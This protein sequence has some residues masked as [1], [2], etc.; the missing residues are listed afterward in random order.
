MSRDDQMLSCSAGR[1]TCTQRTL[2]T[3]RTQ[4]REMLLEQDFSLF[5]HCFGETAGESARI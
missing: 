4:R 1:P 2:H 5:E 3:Q